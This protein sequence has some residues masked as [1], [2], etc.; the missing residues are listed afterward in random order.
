MK[1]KKNKTNSV[2]MA[3]FPSLSNMTMKDVAHA[4]VLLG[5]Y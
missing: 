1:F 2:V 3:V 5:L 4:V